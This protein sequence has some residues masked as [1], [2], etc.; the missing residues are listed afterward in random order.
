MMVMRGFGRNWPRSVTPPPGE[1]DEALRKQELLRSH[2]KAEP[3]I[4]EYCMETYADS[5]PQRMT[6]VCLPLTYGCGS[7]CF[8]FL[9]FLMMLI[10]KCLI[11]LRCLS[12]QIHV[13][14]AIFLA[15][16]HDD[17][18]HVKWRHHQ[19]NFDMSRIWDILKNIWLFSWLFSIDSIQQSFF[20][21]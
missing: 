2:A 14:G 5:N 12:A 6:V 1:I 9:E 20:R 13:Y 11:L 21:I 4:T 15:F 19:H 17:R 3:D 7:V 16:H 10:W 8:I 18:T